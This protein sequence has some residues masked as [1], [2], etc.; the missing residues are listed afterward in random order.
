MKPLPRPGHAEPVALALLS[1]L[2]WLPPAPPGEDLSSWH[3]RFPHPAG[4]E[5]GHVPTAAEQRDMV[6]SESSPGGPQGPSAPPSPPA[7]W[8]HPSVDGTGRCLLL[9]MPFP[10][11]RARSLLSL[12]SPE[13]D[14]TSSE[15]PSWAPPGGGEGAQ[16]GPGSLRPRLRSAS[17]L[18]GPL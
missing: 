17:G 14:V 9:V 15:K 12:H 3:H 10:P 4:E 7:L 5:T 16:R 8:P 1:H 2:P 18:Q 11:P 6:E 13:S